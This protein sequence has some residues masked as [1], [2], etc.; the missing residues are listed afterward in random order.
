MSSSLIDAFAKLCC[1]SEPPP[2]NPP[3]ADNQQ[4]VHGR[5]WVHHLGY[6]RSMRWIVREFFQQTVP[7]LVDPLVELVADYAEGRWYPQINTLIG[8]LETL[9][10]DYFNQYS[11]YANAFWFA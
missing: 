7:G 2:N 1:G 9:D 10:F 4:L 11:G 6:N 8:E 3:A 5:N